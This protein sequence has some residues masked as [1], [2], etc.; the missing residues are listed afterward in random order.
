MVVTTP[1]PSS[2][3][4][5]QEFPFEGYLEDA[6]GN[7][8]ADKVYQIFLNDAG[9]TQGRTKSDGTWSYTISLGPGTY[10]MFV[11]FAGDA[12]YEGC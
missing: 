9:Q 10:A 7:R 2:V 5:G 8:L 4:P 1:P 3:S 12:D 11:K 6:D